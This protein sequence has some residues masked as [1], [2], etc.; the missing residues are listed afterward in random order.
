MTQRITF[1]KLERVWGVQTPRENATWT[2]KESSHVHG[3]NC[4]NC[5]GVRDRTLATLKNRYDN[6]G[7]QGFVEHLAPH[8]GGE[9]MHIAQHHMPFVYICVGGFKPGYTWTYTPRVD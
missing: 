8:G 7:L 9:R 6:A 3:S 1:N 4:R 5:R 2:R